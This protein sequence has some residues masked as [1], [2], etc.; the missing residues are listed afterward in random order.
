ML[1]LDRSDRVRV[2]AAVARRGGSFRVIRVAVIT[3]SLA[4]LLAVPLLGL[5]RIDLWRGQ[6]LLLQE[7]VGII[8]AIQGLVVAL[9]AIYGATFISNAIVGR[10]FC[11]WGCPVGFVS[12]F[13]EDVV[14]NKPL[15]KK[16]LHHASGAGFVATFIA[17]VMAW[18][19]DPAVLIEG[20]WIARLTTCGIFAALWLGGLGHA[21]VWRFGFCMNLCPIGL[22]YRYVTSVAPVGIVF[23]ELPDPCTGCRSCERVC[24]VNLNPK[25]LGKPVGMLDFNDDNAPAPRY[26]DAECLRCGDCIEACR[27]TFK[28]RP[29]ATPPLRFGSINSEDLSDESGGG[30]RSSPPAGESDQAG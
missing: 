10:F 16:I 24:P 8:A 30:P 25:V 2:L 4:I 23:S 18:W 28:K 26:G 11:G 5:V 7:P 27:L 15:T 20:S 1:P 12:R 22:Y 6:H 21:F 3:A 17:A 9:A 29:N 19:V 14:R 13:A